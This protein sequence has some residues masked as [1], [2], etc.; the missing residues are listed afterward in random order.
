MTPETL[1][2]HLQRA[3]VVLTAIG[4]DRLQVNAPT[5]ALTPT[6]R[7]ELFL[8]KA[9]LL[10][11]LRG[12]D[13]WTSATRPVEPK[14]SRRSKVKSAK[15][16]Q[17]ATRAFLSSLGVQRLPLWTVCR[18][19]SATPREA[20][21]LYA[22][23]ALADGLTAT[24][25][26]EQLRRISPCGAQAGSIVREAAERGMEALT[27]ERVAAYISV[28]PYKWELGLRVQDYLTDK[29]QGVSHHAKEGADVEQGSA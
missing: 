28:H 20:D 1:L 4:S 19:I 9:D 26:E 8:Q 6:L 5:G 29:K 14:G 12:M 2:A 15:S 7:A 25:L 3:G 13:A 22:A 10:T 21:L 18:Q 23:L 27:E 24:H 17:Q 16:E 11:S